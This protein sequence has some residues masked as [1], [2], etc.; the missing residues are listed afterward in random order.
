MDQSVLT[1]IRAID[2]EKAFVMCLQ[3]AHEEGVFCG[4]STG[5]N[6]VGAIELAKEIGPGKRVVTFA[7]D[8]WLKYLGGHVYLKKN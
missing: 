7:C 6:V 8:S 5:L 4:A 1:E 2:Q 3:L